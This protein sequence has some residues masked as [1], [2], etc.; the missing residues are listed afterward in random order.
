[1]DVF[2]YIFNEICCFIKASIDTST[3]KIQQIFHR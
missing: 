3:Q 2:K 1:M